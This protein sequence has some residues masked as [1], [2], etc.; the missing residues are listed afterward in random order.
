VGTNP[1][2]DYPK[3]RINGIR[4]KCHRLAFLYMEGYFPENDVDHIDRNPFNNA[5]NNLREVSKTCNMRNCKLCKIN[6]SGISGVNWNKHNKKWVS[7]ITVNKKRVYLG[8][9][10]NKLDAAK[11]RWE[12]EVKYGWPNCNTTSSAYLYIKNYEKRKLKNERNI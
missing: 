9:F 11:A 7:R 10:D 5:W 1:N 12:A 2:S 6:T 4:Y 3:V 8:I